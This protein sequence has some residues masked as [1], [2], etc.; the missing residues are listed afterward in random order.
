M[1]RLLLNCLSMTVLGVTTNPNTGA[2]LYS[3]NVIAKIHCV[4]T[5]QNLYRTNTIWTYSD[6]A[7]YEYDYDLFLHVRYNSNTDYEIQLTNVSVSPIGFYYYDS[8]QE[9]YIAALTDTDNNPS[10][11]LNP[12]FPIIQDYTELSKLYFRSDT[13][14]LDSGYVYIDNTIHYVNSNNQWVL[15][16][17]NLNY[18]A[19]Y[20][21]YYTSLNG[22]QYQSTLPF[23]NREYNGI[24]SDSLNNMFA[25]VFNDNQYDY[26]VEV[27]YGIGYNEGF[28]NGK[29]IGYQ[30]GYEEGFNVNTTP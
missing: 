29:S 6:D 18:S 11:T 22:L 23:N 26:G 3:K 17:Y 19:G 20:Y 14:E 27:G 7:F 10:F 25:Q 12:S 2:Y 1:V 8:N 5:Y 9:E 28:I 24:D 30:Q 21:N 13:K 15:C 16:G 4:D